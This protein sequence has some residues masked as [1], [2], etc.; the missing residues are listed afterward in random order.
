MSS[1]QSSF[2]EYLALLLKSGL[3]TRDWLG[4]IV[5]QFRASKGSGDVGA[6]ARWLIDQGHLTPWQHRRLLDGKTQGFFLGKYKILSHLGSG[7]MSEVYLGEHTMLRRRVAIKVLAVD[8]ISGDSSV[9][10]RF[11]TEAQAIASLDH[12]NIVRAYSVDKR[13]RVYYIAMEYVAG[14][15]LQRVVESHG[16]LA[17]AAAVDHI[18]QAAEGLAHAHAQGFVHRDVK[19][20]NL[21]VD[22]HGTVKILDLGLAKLRRAQG[23]SLT[24]EYN[25]RILGTVDYMA[26]EQALNSH[27]VD[28]MADV[29]GLGCTLY[30]LLAGR[31][32]F[33][34]GTIAQRMVQH[35]HGN[36]PSLFDV[37][38]DA[39]G[40]LV[41]I[42]HRMMA[43]EPRDRLC[44]SEIALALREVTADLPKDGSASVPPAV[45]E[46]LVVDV[47]ADTEITQIPKVAA[48]EDEDLDEVS[49]LLASL[50]EERDSPDASDP[51]HAIMQAEELTLADGEFVI[52]S[53]PA[54]PA[55]APK[56]SSRAPTARPTNALAPTS[57]ASSAARAASVAPARLAPSPTPPKVVSRPATPPLGQP[58]VPTNVQA[59][60]NVSNRTNGRDEK[61]VE[62]AEAAPARGTRD[63][64]RPSRF[65]R[66]RPVD[67]DSSGSNQR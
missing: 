42:C 30:F 50:E 53:R 11:L 35:L 66:G 61:A 22:S 1:F 47:G 17:V 2:E 58:V 8:K 51:T 9:L 10:Q 49:S 44:A 43:R 36:R 7:G 3:A 40:E 27:K 41:R 18:A 21:L 57:A 52:G 26:P 38:P 13:G 14:E 55:G 46:G 6:F 64:V 67:G 45:R 39:P 4:A 20:A 59:P 28:G 12:K 54:K 29:Y 33:P 65:W 24:M 37:R 32:P 34:S 23:R 15:D 25:D 63:G 16:P 19:P 48:G 56:T 62:S 31:P 60:A 5:E